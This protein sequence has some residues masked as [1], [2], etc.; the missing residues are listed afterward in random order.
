MGTIAGWTPVAV[1]PSRA[2]NSRMRRVDVVE[3]ESSL[4]TYLQE[5]EKG[6][7]LLVLIE[8]R[9]VARLV[10]INGGPDETLTREERLAAAGLV[11]LGT[12]DLRMLVETPP[13]GTPEMGASVLR[14]LE[15][16]REDRF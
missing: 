15:E 9:P 8:G 13:P 2:H 1:A 11:R 12:G 5:L 4:R 14:A 7:P 10:P 16:D 3:L 6:E